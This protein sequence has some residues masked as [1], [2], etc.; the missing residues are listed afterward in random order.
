MV[1]RVVPNTPNPTGCG[2]LRTI[3]PTS[4]ASTSED[5][6][7]NYVD[8]PRIM[9]T[10]KSHLIQKTIMCAGQ[11]FLQIASATPA[12]MPIAVPVIR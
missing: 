12:P 9:L 10:N 7:V 1:G 11:R 5:T 3:R 8:A 6:M 4:F 2:G